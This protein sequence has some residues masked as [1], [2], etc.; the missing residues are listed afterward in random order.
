VQQQQ[1]PQQ[2]QNVNAFFSPSQPAQQASGN[3]F[4]ASYVQPSGLAQA[5]P[6]ADP[7]ASLSSFGQPQQQTQQ[8]NNNIF[9]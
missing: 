1:P 4:T 5:A 7:F 9:F 3:P 2:Q 6:A 8:Q